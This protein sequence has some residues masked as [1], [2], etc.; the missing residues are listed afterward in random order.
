MR[1]AYPACAA[2]GRLGRVALEAAGHLPA[3]AC[4]AI[5]RDAPKCRHLDGELAMFQSRRVSYAANGAARLI[6]DSPEG[7]A[8]ACAP[9]AAAAHSAR[10]ATE[11]QLRVTTR[12]LRG[13]E[14][15]PAS[16]PHQEGDVEDALAVGG[17]GWTSPTHARVPP[18]TDGVAATWRVW[19][20]GDLPL[21]DS[22]PGCADR[23]GPVAAVSVRSGTRAC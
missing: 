10:Q 23:A 18:T 12:S 1:T 11:V 22:E 6:A 17:G 14:V 7:A 21:Y 2:S 9:A 8:A 13:G 16:P 19:E 15:N 4:R 5:V 20:G 3:A